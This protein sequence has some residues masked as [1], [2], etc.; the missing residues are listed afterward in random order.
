MMR[1]EN[2]IMVTSILILFAAFFMWFF[3]LIG[4][5]SPYNLLAT[6]IASIAVG[7]NL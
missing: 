1:Y 3:T 5:P 7:I 6:S 2:L 4:V